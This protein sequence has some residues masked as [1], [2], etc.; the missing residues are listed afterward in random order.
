MLELGRAGPEVVTIKASELP[1][2]PIIISPGIDEVIGA[3]E[4]PQG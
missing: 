3:E 2:A 1:K 4:D